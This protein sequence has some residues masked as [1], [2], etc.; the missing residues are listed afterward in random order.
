MPAA[1]GKPRRHVFGETD[2][3][4]AIDGNAVVVVEQDQLAEAEMAGKRDRFLA[5]ALLEATVT[6]EDIGV[7]VD[8]V[9]AELVGQAP[10]RQRHADRTGETLAEGAGGGLDSAG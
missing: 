10:L 1:G 8:E 6:A 5:D 4:R 3:G 9:G 2:A 7:V